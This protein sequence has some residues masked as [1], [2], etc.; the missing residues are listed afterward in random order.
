M[1]YNLFPEKVNTKRGGKGILHQIAHQVL[2]VIWTVYRVLLHPPPK[3]VC[4]HKKHESEH[5][6]KHKVIDID[7][8]DEE[9]RKKEKSKVKKEV[10]D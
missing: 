6:H 2:T 10:M 8:I 1:T 3:R 9:S 4:K 7:S 5:K